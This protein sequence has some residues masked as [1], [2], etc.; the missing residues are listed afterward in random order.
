MKK[1]IKV[2]ATDIKK[3]IVN[4]CEDCPVAQA[5]RRQCRAKMVAVD[6]NYITF[7]RSNQGRL[8]SFVACPPKAVGI[9]VRRFDQN[10]SVKPFE[11]TLD[12]EEIN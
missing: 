6:D 8:R 3:G 7:D 10:K 1:K 11:F 12:Y 4:N 5:I 2:T 9:F